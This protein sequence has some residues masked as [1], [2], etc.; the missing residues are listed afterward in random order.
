MINIIIKSLFAVGLAAVSLYCF[1]FFAGHLMAYTDNVYLHIAFW[2][3]IPCIL[4]G[5]TGVMVK[6]IR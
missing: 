3:G 4:I 6:P 5:V 2:L 1:I